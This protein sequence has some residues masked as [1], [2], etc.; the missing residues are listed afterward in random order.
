MAVAVVLSISVVAAKLVTARLLSLSRSR[1]SRVASL[2]QETTGRLRSVQGQKAL[3]EQNKAAL[4]TRKM[5]LA[6]KK[7]R[8]LEEMKAIETEEE[9][10]QKRT[11]LRRVE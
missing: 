10:R 6:K 5:K 7:A 2:R 3:V 1:I 11:E 9:A 4:T 8:L